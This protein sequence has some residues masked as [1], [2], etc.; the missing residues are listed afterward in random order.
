M[1]LDDAATRLLEHQCVHRPHTLAPET[2]F[3]TRFPAENQEAQTQSSL[4]VLFIPLDITASTICPPQFLPSIQDH[5]AAARTLVLYIF[6]AT[7]ESSSV[8]KRH[9]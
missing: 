3:P 6:T 7:T 4:H 5:P 8:E 1:G 9:S 2:N